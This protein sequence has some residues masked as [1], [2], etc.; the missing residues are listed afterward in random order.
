MQYASK[1]PLAIY[2][3]SQNV[4]I[5]IAPS[6]F[7]PAVN[8]PSSVTSCY[9]DVSKGSYG[10]NHVHVHMDVGSADRLA[11]H[12][13]HITEQVSYRVVPR[14]MGAPYLFDPSIF[15][16]TRRNTS[17][18]DAVLVTPCPTDPTRPL[19]GPSHQVQGLQ[20]LQ[21]KKASVKTFDC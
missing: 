8:A 17:R 1:D 12:D 9:H 21:G 11:Q 6:T 3:L 10:S 2:A 18:P 5:W 19:T 13:L 14:G 16:Q 7:S 15:D 20:G 4:I